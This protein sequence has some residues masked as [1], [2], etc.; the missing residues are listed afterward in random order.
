MADA[1]RLWR[2]VLLGFSVALMAMSLLVRRV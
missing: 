1:Q 2:F